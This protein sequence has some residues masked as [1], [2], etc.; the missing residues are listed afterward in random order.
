[1]FERRRLASRRAFLQRLAQGAGLAL[2]SDGI[3]SAARAADG[4]AIRCNAQSGSATCQNCCPHEH[5]LIRTE[6]APVCGDFGRGYACI[7]YWQQCGDTWRQ[8]THATFIAT[9]SLDWPVSFFVHGYNASERAAI[10]D[11]DKFIA[12]SCCG[13]PFRFVTWVWPARHQFARGVVFNLEDKMQ[14]ARAQA[15]YLAR[16]I[17]EIAPAT[18]LTLI[19]HSF[20]TRVVGGALHDLAV[21]Q[22]GASPLLGR[23][24][25]E[26]VARPMQALLLASALETSAFVAGG[27]AEGALSQVDRLLLTYNPDD[28]ILGYMAHY[29]GRRDLLGLTG[30]SLGASE[31]NTRGQLISFNANSWLGRNHLVP[32]FMR[33]PPLVARLRPHLVYRD[34]VNLEIPA[35]VKP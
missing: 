21:R 5:W 10:A 7:T 33:H 25:G 1:M 8:A 12:A 13:G 18:P 9:M 2:G 22:V 17:E 32:R 11:S 34:A 19:G 20:G 31:S 23:P 3:V 35:T 16:T 15:Y 27:S 6:N 26:T 28:R 14:R 30:L 24:A 29:L 4:D